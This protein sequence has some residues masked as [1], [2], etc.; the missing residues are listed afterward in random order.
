M[1]QRIQNLNFNTIFLIRVIQI[2]NTYFTY[3]LTKS[4]LLN[5]DLS[6]LFPH[7]H[8]HVKEAILFTHKLTS[9]FWYF[10]LYFFV[11]VS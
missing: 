4:S 6:L 2:Y 5:R 7:M 3:F 9:H 11:T 1:K 10:T 8:L